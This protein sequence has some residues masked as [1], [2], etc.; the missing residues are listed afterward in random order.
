[1][2]DGSDQPRA[3]PPSVSAFQFFAEPLAILPLTV[4]APAPTYPP[5]PQRRP[6]IAHTLPSFAGPLFNPSSTAI[7]R[8]PVHPHVLPGPPHLAHA[9]Q[10]FSGPT[11]NTIANLNFPGYGPAG[12]ATLI[13]SLENAKLTLSWGTDIFK[14]YSGREQRVNTT[15]SRPRQRFEGSAFLLDGPGRDLRSALQRSAAAGPTFLLALPH[16]EL[17]LTADSSGSTLT[18]ASTAECDWAIVTQRVVVIGVDGSTAQAVIQAVTSTT[19]RLDITPSAQAGA[20]ILPLVQV[21]LDPQQ[22]FSRFPVN[23]EFWSIR[24]MANVFGWVGQDRLG[25][26]AQILTYASGL[27]AASALTDS[28]LPIWDRS[29]AVEG[30]ALESMISLAETVDFGALPF[31]AGGAPA[32]DWSRS[33]KY[34][35]ADPVDWQ[36]FKAF[37]RQIRGRQ[38]AFLLSTNHADLI[39][40][41]VVGATLKVQSSSISG[42]G[43]YTGWYTST[44][45][46]RL[47][48][49]KTTGAI[50]YVAVTAPPVDNHDGTLSLSLDATATGT[51]V[52]ISF[53]ERVRLD[54]NDSDDI[55]V[56]WDGGMFSVDLL[57]RVV[58]A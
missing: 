6:A 47:A 12:A 30:T 20:R 34:S 18:V 56:T 42:A 11:A 40:V 9:F 5:I 22:G 27:V 29:N 36:W 43:D 7:Q 26:G 57:A 24:A 58:Q 28:D 14:S 23:V 45:H 2:N 17:A 48:L 8:P 19:I 55:P 3:R 4:V 16:E 13:L 32:P 50:Q 41:S 52:A 10:F 46:R 38:R 15:G 49:T 44:A 35:S 53:A 25:V 21:L 31:A 37:L 51:I 54:N 39:F 33:I 1:V